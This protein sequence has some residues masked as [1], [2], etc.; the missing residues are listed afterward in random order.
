[1]QKKYDYIFSGAGCA[2][3]SLVHRMMNQPFF[4]GKKILMVDRDAKRSNDRTW[5]FWEK[6]QGYFENLVSHSWKSIWVKHAEHEMKISI[7]PYRYKM[8]RGIDFYDLVI[9]Q[10]QQNANVDFLQADISAIQHTAR[11]AVL[12]TSAGHFNARIVFNSA[13]RDELLPTKDEYHL[14]QHF[15]GWII[16]TQEAAFD[17]L[18]ATLMDFRIDQSPGTSFVYTMPFSSTK[19]LI[20]YTLFTEKLL[21]PPAYEAALSAYIKDVLHI[22]HYTIG[23][24]EFG[25]IPMTNHKFPKKQGNIFNIGT[26]GGVTKAS[27]GYT[28]RFIQR[29]ADII[30]HQLASGNALT[31]LQTSPRFHFYDAVLLKILA[32]KKLS[33]ADIFSRLFRR[34][35]AST[36]FRFLDNESTLAEEVPLLL[37]LPIAPFARAAVSLL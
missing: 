20:E 13:L 26:A 37:S 8:I 15:K 23:E 21:E 1:V 11:G 12:E 6:G 22:D 3:L 35:D 18:S 14:L 19:A 16:E 2:A 29:E 32:E 36:V 4:A 33:G 10:A 9:G 24:K 5:C 28:F 17:P 27:S 30:C 25:V 34:N 31:G 7:D